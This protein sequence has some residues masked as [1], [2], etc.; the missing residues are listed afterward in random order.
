MEIPDHLSHVPW[1]TCVQ[2]KKQ[3]LEP[4]MEQLTA[5]KLKKEFD[6]VVYCHPV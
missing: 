1:E 5:S 2:D 6:K 3:Q 4:Y